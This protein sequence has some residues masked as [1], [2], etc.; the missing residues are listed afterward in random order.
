MPDRTQGR[1]QAFTLI[2]LLVV[3]SIIAVLIALLLPAVQSAREAARRMQCKNNLKQMG[4][5][6]ANY[7]SSFGVFPPARLGHVNPADPTKWVEQWASWAI[8][9]L[10]YVDQA[11][12]YGLYNTNFKWNDPVNAQVSTTRLGV[13]SCPTSPNGNGVD[14]NQGTVAPVT[15]DYMATASVSYKL[16]QAIPGSPSTL[17]TKDD[18]AGTAMRNG[19]M[20]KAGNPFKDA[21]YLQFRPSRMTDITDGAS[22]T[23]VLVE[24]AGAPYAYGP[25]RTPFAVGGPFA[26]STNVADYTATNGN[27]MYVQVKGAAWADPDRVGG[28][29]GCTLDGFKSG[30]GTTPL[31]IMNVSNDNEPYSFHAGGVNAL[32]ADG[33]VR[34]VSQN[35]DLRTWAGLITRGG[36]EVLGEF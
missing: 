12:L 34:F 26:S 29:A 30:P 27:G 33:S 8:M 5:A 16:Y 10:P 13:Y 31:A 35:L 24:M 21:T 9:I 4:L 36:G 2:E 1:R 3:I 18:P 17:T 22:N 28:L 6:L 19:V 20:V 32:L 15:G 14:P 25:N 11:N 7:E 23:I